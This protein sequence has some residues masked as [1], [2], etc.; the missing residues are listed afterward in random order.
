[1]R[2]AE[3]PVAAVGRGYGDA[4]EIGGKMYLD[5]AAGLRPGDIVKARVR[6]AGDYDLRCSRREIGS[7]ARPRA[8]GLRTTGVVE[9]AL[10]QLGAAKNGAFPGGALEHRPFEGGAGQVGAVEHRFAEVGARKVGAPEI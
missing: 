9:G 3:R 8:S 7:R 2:E 6:H 5:E 4:P 1:M 10:R